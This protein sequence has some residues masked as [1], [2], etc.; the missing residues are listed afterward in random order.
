MR[1]RLSLIVSVS[2]EMQFFVHGLA[3]SGKS[4]FLE[5]LKASFGDY[6]RVA[7]FETFLQ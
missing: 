1:G 4:T 5:S 3:A 6:A 2:E 7:D